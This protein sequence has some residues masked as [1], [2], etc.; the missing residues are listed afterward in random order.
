M[1]RALRWAAAWRRRR[2]APLATSLLLPLP[3]H[4][5]PHAEEPPQPSRPVQPAAAPEPEAGPS[6]SGAGASGSGG[7]SSGG[8]S[9]GSG[10][11][12]SGDDLKAFLAAAKGPGG[13]QAAL[14]AAGGPT[15]EELPP[16][17]GGE[18]EE[19]GSA[20]PKA[21]TLDD[22]EFAKYWKAPVAG[23]WGLEGWGG[24]IR[25]CSPQSSERAG[26]GC[27]R[28]RVCR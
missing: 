12:L 5:C 11:S 14:R 27:G 4:C 23:A 19:A 13:L 1:S 21:A 20:Q 17:G 7:G 26:G 10:I 24:V 22:P 28:V 18:E 3:S 15:F 9:G 6:T 25:V 2:L 8:S 16:G